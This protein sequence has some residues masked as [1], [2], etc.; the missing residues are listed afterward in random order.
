MIICEGCEKPIHEG[1]KVLIIKFPNEDEFIVHKS[2]V[3]LLEIEG[4]GEGIG[5]FEKEGTT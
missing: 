1:D 3:C 4:F 2:F 5:S